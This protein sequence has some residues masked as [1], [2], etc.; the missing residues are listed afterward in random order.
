M[1]FKRIHM[2]DAIKRTNWCRLLAE[3]TLEEAL[4][5]AEKHN[6]EVTEAIDC[7]TC[8]Q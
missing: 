5:L 4:A 7:R 3:M 2:V 8:Y 1:T 6:V